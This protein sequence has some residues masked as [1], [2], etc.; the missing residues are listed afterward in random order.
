MWRPFTNSLGPR[1]AALCT[2]NCGALRAELDRSTAMATI[3]TLSKTRPD[4]DGSPGRNPQL[5]AHRGTLRSGGSLRREQRTA[6]TRTDPM[7][8]YWGS[9]LLDVTV[10]ENYLVSDSCFSVLEVR[11]QRCRCQLHGPP[12]FQ[13]L[14]KATFRRAAL[15]TGTKNLAICATRVLNS[16]GSRWLLFF[17]E[18]AIH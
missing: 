2:T 16:I 6:A 12:G 10:N 8:R 1:S 13:A 5:L 4:V 7:Q 3:A 9:C 15:V 17:S 18:K 11:L 14:V